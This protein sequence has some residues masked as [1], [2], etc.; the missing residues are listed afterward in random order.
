M[1]IHIIFDSICQTP[2]DSI[3]NFIVPRLFIININIVED[4]VMNEHLNHLISMG[5]NSPISIKDGNG[6]D[7]FNYD[8]F[9]LFR[10]IR[11]IALQV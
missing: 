1:H 2:V 3:L 8:I 5:K 6:L 7:I 4:V 11:Y 10:I 9:M